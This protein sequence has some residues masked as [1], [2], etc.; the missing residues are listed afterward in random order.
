MFI[1]SS[2]EIREAML[3]MTRRQHRSRGAWIFAAVAGFLLMGFTLYWSWGQ[4]ALA[5]RLIG[6]AAIFAALV[7][8]TSFVLP[9]IIGRIWGIMQERRNPALRDPVD[10]EIHEDGIRFTGPNGEWHQP[11]KNFIAMAESRR[12]ILLYP[13]PALVNILPKRELS[14]DD[15]TL[16]R[17]R[18]GPEGRA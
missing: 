15:M 4:P 1:L 12:L 17:R 8:L 10:V 6:S 18:L 7:A 2:A 13:G 9:E 5:S 3:I 16:I 11:W 14:N